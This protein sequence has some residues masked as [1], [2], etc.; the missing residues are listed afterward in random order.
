MDRFIH[1]H[2]RRTYMR[3]RRPAGRSRN[4]HEVSFVRVTIGSSDSQESRI[5]KHEEMLINRVHR[6][7][8]FA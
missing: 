5:A 3:A 1:M 4:S 2:A 6:D 8:S 7:V